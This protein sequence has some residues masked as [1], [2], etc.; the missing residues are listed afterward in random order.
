MSLKRSIK[1]L[2]RF[3]RAGRPNTFTYHAQIYIEMNIWEEIPLQPFSALPFAFAS[4]YFQRFWTRVNLLICCSLRVL[5]ILTLIRITNW[6]ASPLARVYKRPHEYKLTSKCEN[7]GYVRSGDKKKPRA[8]VS[9]VIASRL[10]ITELPPRVR[11]PNVRSFFKKWN[12]PF[13][14]ASDQE[15]RIK[16]CRLCLHGAFL[17]G[18]FHVTSGNFETVTRTRLKIITCRTILLERGNELTLTFV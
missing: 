12:Q 16:L 14:W 7:S 1:R 11:L 5:N 4:C 8:N 6:V 9:S 15:C 10:V 18:H 2:K 3:W 13:I 17:W